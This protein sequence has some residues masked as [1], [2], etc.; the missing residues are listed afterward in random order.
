MHLPEW[1]ITLEND[2]II[3]AVNW[4]THAAALIAVREVVFIHEQ[5]VPVELEWDGMDEN[6][7][8]LLA[9]MDAGEIIGCARL[10]GDGSIGR[11]AVLKSWRGCGVGRALLEKAVSLYRQQGIHTIT[12]SAQVHAVPFYEKSGFQVCSTPYPDAGIMHVDMRL[13]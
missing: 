13:I 6:A 9:Q 7:L 2:F 5:Q 10:I 3:K 12:L 8:H 11:M 4:K 1:N